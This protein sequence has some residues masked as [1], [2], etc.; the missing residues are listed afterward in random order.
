MDEQLRQVYRLHVTTRRKLP[1]KRTL[2]KRFG[3]PIHAIQKRAATLGLCRQKEKPWCEQELNLLEKHA[4]KSEG[5]IERLFRAAGFKRSQNAIHVK[6]NRHFV[7][8]RVE[9]YPFY[10]AR[11]LSQLLGIDSHSIKAWIKGGL[12]K[13]ERQ[14]TAHEGDRDF[15]MI[16]PEEVRQFLTANPL[17]FDIRKVDQ[18]WFM[19][20][21]TNR[22]AESAYRE[23]KAAA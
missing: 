9:H 17:A 22:G 2:A 11:R 13:A 14:G 5:R 19:D 8:G 18:L 16:Y 20:L 23:H 10:S 21:L 6:R 4:W 15:W 3:F 12:L 7:G 1:I